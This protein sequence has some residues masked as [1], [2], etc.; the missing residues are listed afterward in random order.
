MEWM[1]EDRIEI[2]YYWHTGDERLGLCETTDRN[3]SNRDG[4]IG[5]RRSSFIIRP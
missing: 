3:W 4:S 2:A 1:C 5:Y